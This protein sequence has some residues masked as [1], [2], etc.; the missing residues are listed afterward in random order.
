MENEVWK[1]I[2]NFEN[3]Y[4]I[5]NFGNVKSLKRNNYILNGIY[6]KDGYKRVCLYKKENN[7]ETRTYKYIHRLVAQAFIPNPNK[8]PEVNH[9]NEI[10]DC[11]EAFN[12]EWCSAKYNCNYGNRNK[13]I[14]KQILQF[15]TNKN[16]IQKW[17]SIKKASQELNIDNSS[18]TKCCKGKR[19]KAGGY[20]WEYI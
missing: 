15:D 18:I 13:K 4:Q 17:D 3:L 1:D 5:S 16:L 14:R 7:N 2:P 19:K 12:L 10:K 11:N 8:L 9:K 6:D 20:S